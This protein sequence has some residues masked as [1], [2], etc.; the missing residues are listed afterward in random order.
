MAHDLVIRGG[1]LVDGTGA[2]AR[3]ADVTVDDGRISAVLEAGTAGVADREIDVI[4][5]DGHRLKGTCA[6]YGAPRLAM[7]CRRSG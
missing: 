5:R 4:A 6:T 2:P 7:I 3:T 1:Q